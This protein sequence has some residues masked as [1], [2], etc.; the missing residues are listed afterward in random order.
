MAPHAGGG[1]Q[2]EAG[3]GGWGEARDSYGQLFPDGRERRKWSERDPGS[4]EDVGGWR[5]LNIG[6]EVICVNFTFL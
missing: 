3:G 2:N 5:G 4:R 1:S 6:E